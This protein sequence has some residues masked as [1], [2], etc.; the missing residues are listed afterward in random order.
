V[1]QAP[2]LAPAKS[3]TR[4][5]SEAASP[6]ETKP[7]TA[8]WRSTILKEAKAAADRGIKTPTEALSAFAR[9]L[10]LDDAEQV[11]KPLVVKG[12]ALDL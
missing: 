7:A 10:D 12:R 4:R 8:D 9:E 3:S 1:W 5:T 2:K 6:V 11:Y